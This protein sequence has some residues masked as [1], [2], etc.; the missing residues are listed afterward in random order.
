MRNGLSSPTM[1]YKATQ[2]SDRKAFRFLHDQ[3]GMDH[4]ILGMLLN[5]L[6]CKV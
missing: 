6:H 4:R 2:D 1:A 5:D 3:A